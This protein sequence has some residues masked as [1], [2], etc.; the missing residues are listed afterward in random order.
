MI[1][2][3]FRDWKFEEVELTFGIE[4][5]YDHPLLIDWLSVKNVPNEGDSQMLEN[6]RYKLSRSINTYNEEELKMAFIA[7]LLYL[8]PFEKTGLRFFADRPFTFEYGQDETGNSLV[9]A[10]RVDW[11]LAQGRQEP[12]EPRVFLH[13]YKREVEAAGD[14]LGQLLI[15]MVGAQRGNA[16]R[17]NTEAFPLYGCYVLG[18]NWFFV[19]L[20]D[21][22]YAVSDAYV[23]TQEDIY[24]IYSAMY[25]VQRRVE[26]L[27]A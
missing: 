25:E 20:E 23:A 1:T 6:L 7:P 18:R 17:Q 15:A 9:A 21:Q 2:K 16:Q 26:V 27:V 13:E 24:G 19:I 5:T 10:G 3:A 14:P 12:R 4:Q 22:Q 8:V 11:L